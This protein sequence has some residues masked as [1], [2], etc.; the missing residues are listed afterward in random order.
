[1]ACLKHENL[2]YIINKI[3]PEYETKKEYETR[4][5]IKITKNVSAT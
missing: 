2:G 3:G 4:S 1:M 5:K